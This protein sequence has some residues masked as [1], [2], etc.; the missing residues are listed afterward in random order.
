MRSCSRVLQRGVF[1][2]RPAEMSVANLVLRLRKLDVKVWVEGDQLRLSPEHSLTPELRL[3]LGDAGPELIR[4]LREHSPEVA[5]PSAP[6]IERVPRDTLLPLSF[7]QQRFWFLSQLG[8]PAA[9]SMIAALRLRGPLDLVALEWSLGEIVRR[10]ETLRTTLQLVHGQPTQVIAPT[11]DPEMTTVDLASLADPIAEAKRLAQAQFDSTFDLTTGPLF[12]FMLLVLGADDHVL[13]APFHHII[14]DRWS[15]GV[16]FHEM[17]ALYSA[18]I[19][20]EPSP[21][22]ELRVQYA[23]YACWQRDGYA[24]QRDKHL[25]YWLEQLRGLPS[26]ELPTDRPRPAVQTYNGMTRQMTIPAGAAAD[27]RALGTAENC[28]FFMAMLAGFKVLLA[29]YSGQQDIV[30]G[31]PIA[32]RPDVDTELMIGPF[33]NSLVLRTDLSGTPSFRELL[34]RVR[35][36]ALGAY[37]H[38]E[39]PFEQLLVELRPERDLSRSPVFQVMFNQLDQ[40]LPPSFA[41]IEVSSLAPDTVTAKLELTVTLEEC[42][43]GVITTFEYNTDLFD[44]A[45]IERMGQHWIAL[46]IA[47][48][49]QPDRS[50]WELPL[51]T[52]AEQQLLAAKNRTTQDFGRDMRF[53]RLFEER[54]EM[55]PDATAASCGDESLTYA[56]LNARANR[57]ADYLR[58]LGG[59][60]DVP[61]GVS[62]ERSLDM[63]VALLGIM[64]SGAAYVPL[65]PAYPNDRM[66]FII[67]DAGIELMVTQESL[68]GELPDD[69]PNLV[70]LDADAE[71][72]AACSDANP[73]PR[74]GAEDLAYVIFTSGSTGRPKGVQIEHRALANFLCSMAVRPGM[75]ADDVLVAVTTISFDI[76]G[77]ELYLPLLVGGQVVIAPR[78]TES[79]GRQL[80]ELITS[81]GAS[82]V[83]ATPAT[84]QLLLESGWSGDPELKALCGG[85]AL[86]RDLAER[87]LPKCRALWNMYGPTETTIWSLVRK[88]QSSDGQVPIGDP[89][90]NTVLHLLDTHQQ[91][92]PSGPRGVDEGGAV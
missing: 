61:V 43:E 90:A 87:I 49:Q 47:A 71:A 74:S 17:S 33:L 9:Y 70:R 45:T 56:E 22:D 3:E 28:T 32:N 16:L 29:R 20:G 37:Q 46:L 18:R 72:I 34:Q 67:E 1:D 60:R 41:G 27:I 31:T 50:V 30:I 75:T 59:A 80:A 10:H 38:Q 24:R 79:D 84:W 62:V 83:Q 8:D 11:G 52:P 7:A 5:E 26:L 42:E 68:R 48:A 4:F 12:R 78:G 51:L 91:P 89:I 36:V 65:D 15:Y 2:R 85:E 40:A 6:S 54:V 77:L 86:P 44:D 63:L 53:F 76:A 19:K 82:I 66:A 92:V 23:D 69:L 21:L 58:R 39:L 13:L 14:S 25:P 55:S 73:E 81:A 64:K 35:Q 88:V 57:L